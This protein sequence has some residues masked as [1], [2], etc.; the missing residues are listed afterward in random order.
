MKTIWKYEIAI[1]DRQTLKV[2]CGGKAIHVGMDPSG[3]ECIWFEVET[4]NNEYYTTIFVVCT[5]NPI[6]QEATQHVGSLVR[7]WMVWHVYC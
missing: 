4:E 2:P 3:A 7:G 5:G 6:P 1:T